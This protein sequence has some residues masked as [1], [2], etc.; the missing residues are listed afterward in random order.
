[1]KLKGGPYI[2]GSLLGWGY[3]TGPLTHPTCPFTH[4]SQYYTRQLEFFVNG[5]F[6][7]HEIYDSG[8]EWYIL[9]YG[10]ES[11]MNLDSNDMRYEN[12]HDCTIQEDQGVTL[13]H[14]FAN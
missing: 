1:M 13:M 6:V 14:F 9:F 5:C 12:V 3:S 8:E 10:E 11:C 2:T 4:P 7:N